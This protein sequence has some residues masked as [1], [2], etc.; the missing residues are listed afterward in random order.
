VLPKARQNEDNYMKRYLIGEGRGYTLNWTR[1]K[2]GLAQE[3]PNTA[4]A[5]VESKGIYDY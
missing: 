2:S 5:A 3:K 1:E 4:K